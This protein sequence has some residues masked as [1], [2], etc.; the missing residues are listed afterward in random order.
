[1]VIWMKKNKGIFFQ[2]SVGTDF[3][4]LNLVTLPQR[5]FGDLVIGNLVILPQSDV[6]NIYFFKSATYKNTEN[7]FINV[8]LQCDSPDGF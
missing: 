8:P 7:T 2:M 3:S 4:N 6:K 1:M 5:V